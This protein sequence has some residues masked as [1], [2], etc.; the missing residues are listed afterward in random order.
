[1]T[2]KPTFEVPESVRKMAEQA[3]AQSHAA[4]MQLMDMIS[5]AQSTA[6]QSFGAQ[7]PAMQALQPLQ[8]R[9]MQFTQTNLTNGFEMAAELA[10]ARDMPDY[11]SIQTRHAQKQLAV[12]QSQVQE[13]AHLMQAAAHG[14][15]PKA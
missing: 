2:D 9:I 14:A 4:S 15:S 13:L 10:R 5:K 3:V 12:Y 1:M 8:A 6:M 7:M 11:F